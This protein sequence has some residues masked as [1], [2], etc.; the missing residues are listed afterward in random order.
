MQI[1]FSA[2]TNII[3]VGTNLKLMIIMIKMIIIIIIIKIKVQK[4]YYFVQE[5]LPTT[6][7]SSLNNLVNEISERLDNTTLLEVSQS[8]IQ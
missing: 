3:F 5:V 8:D 2:Y 1:I 4:K 7:M 6:L